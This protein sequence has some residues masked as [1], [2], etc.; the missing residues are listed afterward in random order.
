MAR[1]GVTL[2]AC[3]LLLAGASVGVTV[4]AQTVRRI[5]ALIGAA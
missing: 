5:A 2:L 4:I 3:V 1:G